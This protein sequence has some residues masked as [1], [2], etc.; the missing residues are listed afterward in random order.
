MSLR[1]GDLL[2]ALGAVGLLVLLFLDWF[3][4]QAVVVS[5]LG[6]AAGTL[7][8][9]GWGALGWFAVLVVALM[10]ALA[11]LVV[12]LL[13]AGAADGWNL[14][15]AVVLVVLSPLTLLLLVVR[16]L[17]AQ[18]GLG[19]GLPNGAVDVTTAGWLGLLAA[20]ALVLGSWWSI[21][22]ERRGV[23]SRQVPPAPARPA[24]PAEGPGEGSPASAN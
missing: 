7:S 12:V 9:T 16:V 13:A 1:P 6:V 19:A 17:W 15:P 23:R 18:P 2:L 8:T 22:D 4:A 11:L 14:P 3:T 24:P 21:H 10:I 20:L 5:R